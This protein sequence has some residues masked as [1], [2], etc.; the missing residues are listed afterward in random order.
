MIR[1]R[2]KEENGRLQLS[3]E[4]HAGYAPAGQDI[5]CAAASMLGQTL[6]QAVCGAEG[7]QARCRV[8]PG[9]L[10]LLCAATPE[11]RVMFLM[12][13]AGFSALAGR[14]G[15][16]VRVEGPGGAEEGSVMPGE[17]A[18]NPVN[19]QAERK[20]HAKDARQQSEAEMAGKQATADS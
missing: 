5:V 11:T 1:I 18:D 19:K 9:R 8:K 20:K 10:E 2:F 12:A 14:Y 7:A 15:A 4:G 3:M 6:V 16:W 13:Q 17:N